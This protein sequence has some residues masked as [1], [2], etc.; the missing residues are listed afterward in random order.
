MSAFH[1][2]YSEWL[3]LHIF[4]SVS[5]HTSD[6]IMAPCCMNSAISTHFLSQKTVAISFLANNVCLNFFSLFGECVC[7]HCFDCSLVSTFA[8]ENQD[9]SCYLYDVIEKFIAIFVVS[10]IK[11]KARPILSIFGNH[12][13]QNL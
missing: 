11:V 1:A 12:L 9:S 3:A 2:F 13:A 8:N 7:I 10:L 5:Q 6:V 4:F